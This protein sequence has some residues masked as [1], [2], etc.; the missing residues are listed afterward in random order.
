MHRNVYCSTIY[1]SQDMGSNLNVHQQ[2]NDKDVV[3]IYNRIL[4]SREIKIK[5]YRTNVW[6]PSRERGWGGM[7]WELEIDI[8]TLL[9]IKWITNG[10]LLYSTGNCTQCS[11]VT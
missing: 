9:Y 10:N 4:L 2:R 11:I 1:N 7:N 6:T 3:R 8:Y 5:T